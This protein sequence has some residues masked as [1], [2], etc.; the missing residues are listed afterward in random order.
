MRFANDTNFHLRMAALLLGAMF[1][2]YLAATRLHTWSAPQIGVVTFVL[3]LV[4]V[5]MTAF[6]HGRAQAE[7]LRVLRDR[8]D[9]LSRQV[10]ALEDDTRARRSLPR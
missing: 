4:W 7:E 3:G 9:R 5:A 2:E 10:E 1:L 8:V 6:H